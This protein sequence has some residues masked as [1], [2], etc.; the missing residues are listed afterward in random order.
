V[1]KA[2]V[3]IHFA[4]SQ[5]NETRHVCAFFSS[6]EEPYRALLPFIRDGF[7]CGDKAVS[8][9]RSV[10]RHSRCRLAGVQAH[11]RAPGGGHVDV[12]PGPSGHSRL[13]GDGLCEIAASQQ[14]SMHSFRP[15]TRPEPARSCR[16]CLFGRGLARESGHEVPSLRHGHQVSRY[17]GAIA[18]VGGCE[19]N[20]RV[21]RIVLRR[22]IG[23]SR[24][25]KQPSRSGV[26]RTWG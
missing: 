17:L 1:K 18:S 7:E 25:M 9:A 14:H 2:T 20:S 13:H 21:C 12:G 26:R 22:P 16:K 11:D 8:C 4:G 23:A 6:E 3:P 19:L 15:P 5:L 10:A 24:A